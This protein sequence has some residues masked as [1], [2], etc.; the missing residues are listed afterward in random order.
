MFQEKKKIKPSW[1]VC[2]IEL[3]SLS[4]DGKVEVTKEGVKL[5]TMGP[6]K[7][8][9]ELAILYNCTR[10]ATVKSKVILEF[11]FEVMLTYTDIWSGQNTLWFIIDF[12]KLSCALKHSCFINS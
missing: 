8:F 9:G 3:C 1:K 5:C 4:T 7:V 11:N 10:T 6:G 12:M 2:D